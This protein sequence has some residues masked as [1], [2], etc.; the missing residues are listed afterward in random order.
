MRES[1]SLT[2][3][4]LRRE[5]KTLKAKTSGNKVELVRRLDEIRNGVTEV[6]EEDNKTRR[7]NA[8]RYFDEEA[9]ES[10][11]SEEEDGDDE[12]GIVSLH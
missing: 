2:V 7:R 3:I 5:L 11:D 6:I 12:G 4:Q 9:K 1:N 10:N 8:S